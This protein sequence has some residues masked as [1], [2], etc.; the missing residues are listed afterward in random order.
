MTTTLPEIQTDPASLHDVAIDLTGADEIALD[1]ETYGADRDAFNPWRGNIRLLQVRRPGGN[2]WVLDLQAIGY[3]LGPLKPVLERSVVV[4]H[5]AK[6]DVRWLRVKCGVNIRDIVCTLTAA[7]LLNAGKHDSNSLDACL[8]RYLDIPPGEDHGGSD[9]SGSL[10]ESQIAYAARDVEHLRNLWRVLSHEIDSNGLRDVWEAEKRLLP[11]TIDMECRGLLLDRSKLEVFRR[12]AETEK[13]RF[14]DRLLGTLNLPAA[15][16]QTLAGFPVERSTIKLNSPQQMLAALRRV[17]GV[18]GLVSTDVKDLANFRGIPA[19]DALLDYRRVTKELQFTAIYGNS[20][21]EDGRIH[22]TF[23]QMGSRA[24]RFSA[25]DPNLQQ[26][27]RGEM[28]E[29]F[30]AGEGRKF[31]VADYSQVELR[32]AAAHADERFMLDAY[33]EGADLHRRTAAIVLGK[34]EDE[35]TKDDRQLAKAVNFGLIYGSG[36]SG[37]KDYAKRSYGVEMTFRRAEDIRR[38]FFAGYPSLAKWHKQCHDKARDPGVTATRTAM[39]RRRYLPPYDGH[40]STW[41]RFT[42]LCNSPIQ[43]TAADGMKLAIVRLADALPPDA[44]VVSTVHDEVIVDVP[45]DRADELAELVTDTMQTAM[46]E[47]VP[48]VPFE[49][50]AG[51][52]DDWSAK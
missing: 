17:P 50:E 21:C 7:Q 3:D 44:Y 5:N 8:E 33:R 49:V 24:G 37:L 18:E 41:E 51:I 4:A 38:K 31:I 14:T 13:R 23:K 42:T 29:F 39:G 35:V 27:K 22:A 28:R 46:E 16:Q 36:A 47:L 15:P 52:G 32:T 20:V 2:P 19:I 9:W 11:V 10:T 6:F 26:V 25:A 43:G 34:D 30:V 40:S 48:G 12:R 1:V 45:A